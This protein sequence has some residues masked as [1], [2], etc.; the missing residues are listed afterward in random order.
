[1]GM[2]CMNFLIKWWIIPQKL[3][4]DAKK[5]T[6]ICLEKA[7]RLQGKGLVDGFTLCSDYCL[8]SGPFLSPCAVWGVYSALS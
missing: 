8:N 5:R 4:D 1:M 7:Q 2:V 3:K 6:D